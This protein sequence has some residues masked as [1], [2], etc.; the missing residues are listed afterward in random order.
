MADSAAFEQLVLSLASGRF[1]DLRT[2]HAD[3]F[4]VLDVVLSIPDPLMVVVTQRSK[5][6]IRHV[7]RVTPSYEAGKVR[8]ERW[9]T[10][11]NQEIGVREPVTD[12]PVQVIE[13]HILGLALMA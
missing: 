9:Q 6:T 4:L 1:A 5:P 8:A 10:Q 11:D 12:F 2:P 3:G 13:S 7:F